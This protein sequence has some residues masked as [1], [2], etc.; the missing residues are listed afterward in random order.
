MIIGEAPG[1]REDEIGKPFAGKA[2]K[3]L[4]KQ[5]SDIGLSREDVYI[6][7]V[8]KCRPP[9]N[10][11]PTSTEMKACR[12][13]LDKELQEVNPKNVFLLGAMALK[14]FTRK[15]KITRMRGKRIEHEGRILMPG[16]HPAAI[17]HDPGKTKALE[18]DFQAFKRLLDGEEEQESKFEWKMIT[19]T[20]FNQ[21]L[22]ELMESDEVAYDIETSRLEPFFEDSFVRMISFALPSGRTWLLPLETEHGP[23]NGDRTTQRTILARILAVIEEYEIKGIAQ[24]GKFESQWLQEIY[25]L[26]FPLDFDTM[27][28]SH[29]LDENSDHDLE[30]QARTHLG[31]STWDIELK[32]KQGFDITITEFLRVAEYCGK[33]SHYTLRLKSAYMSHFRKDPV[34]R[35]LFFKLVMPV[36]RVYQDTEMRG[37]TINLKAMNSL[38]KEFT[39]KRERLLKRLNDL[40]GGEVNWNSPAQVAEVI[41]GKLELKPVEETA[42][43]KPSTAESTLLRLRDKHPLPAILLDYRG[44]EKNLNTYINGLVPLM[45]GDKLYISTKLHG[46]VTGRFSSRL[47]QIPRESSIRSIFTAPK[48]WRFF[49]ADYGQIELRIAAMYSGDQ[50]MKMIFQTGGDIH[51][52]TA[53]EVLG[54][55]VEDLTKEQR[56]KAK[57]IN[58]GFVYGMGW[59]KFII[60]ARDNYGVT[61]TPKE[62]KAYRRRFFEL[63]N[64][65]PAWHERQRRIVNRQGF[66]ESPT[67]RRR[68]LPGALSNEDDIRSEAERQAINSPVQG[69]GSGDLKA[70]GMIEIHEKM[71]PEELQLLGE[72]H[73]SILGIVREDKLEL[74]HRLKCIMESPK[75]LKDFEIN[76]TVPIVVDIEIGDWGAGRIME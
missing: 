32:L 23:H 3:V 73:D 21:F 76:M 15:A 57:P 26:K 18:Q 24:N 55:P 31:V 63:F 9:E 27:L 53:S 44:V 36:A 20:S 52:T 74:L 72:V 41:F 67:G 60:Y 7:N 45:V 39:R 4:D 58:F 42:G 38:R 68:R 59:Y 71:N 65:L 16:F 33:D 13:Y 22:V 70:M 56:K 30:Y 11:K 35:R 46:T 54:V 43:G 40:A 64:G 47:H 12:E 48:G 62:S 51:S 25:G 49:Q 10:R 37:F 19:R 17:L 69:F 75:L 50:R 14:A 2:G 28:A 61:V 66:V 5:L 8:V 29:V 6:T 34:L 1:F